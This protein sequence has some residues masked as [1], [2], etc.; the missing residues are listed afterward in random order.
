[1][2]DF[3]NKY[4]KG[5]LICLLIAIPSW[6]IGKGVSSDDHCHYDSCRMIITMFW[7]DKEA[8]A[9]IRTSR[10]VYRRLF[11]L[12]GFGMNLG[13]IL[14]E[15]DFTNHCLFYYYIFSTCVVMKKVFK[16]MHSKYIGLVGVGF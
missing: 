2:D 7:N 13:V 4:G 1:M 9:G 11:V 14:F 12:L 10:M 3:I 5:I 6:I 16:K 15:T 8:E